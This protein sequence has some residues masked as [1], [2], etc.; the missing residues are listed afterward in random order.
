MGI[1]DKV[2]TVL[3]YKYMS[4]KVKVLLLKYR[5]AHWAQFEVHVDE[6]EMIPTGS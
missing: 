4:K 6:S 5:R 1:I 2:M 3:T